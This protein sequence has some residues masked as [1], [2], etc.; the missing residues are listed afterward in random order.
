MSMNN[1]LYPSTYFKADNNVPAWY[2]FLLKSELLAEHLSNPDPEPSGCSLIKQFFDQ[3]NKPVNDQGQ[4][5]PPPDNKKNRSL[6]FLALQSAALLQWDL[7]IFEKR[8]PIVARHQLFME[9]MKACK[10]GIPLAQQTDLGNAIEKLH[11]HALMSLVLYCRWSARTVVKST[12][13]SKP[14]GRV[15]PTVPQSVPYQANAQQRC[16]ELRDQI[17]GMLKDQIYDIVQFLEAILHHVKRVVYLPNHTVFETQQL[18]EGNAAGILVTC[19]EMHAQICYDLGCLHF[20]HTF[21]E[22]AREMFGHVGEWLK[23]LPEKSSQFCNIDETTLAGYQTACAMMNKQVPNSNL[24]DS[25]DNESLFLKIRSCLTKKGSVLRELRELIL[26]DVY[27]KELST[28]FLDEVELELIRNQGNF[29]GSDTIFDVKWCNAI[30][31]AIRGLDQPTGL[32]TYDMN[33]AQLQ[34]IVGFVQQVAGYVNQTESKCL[35]RFLYSMANNFSDRTLRE[36][37]LNFEITRRLIGVDHR[38]ELLVRLQTENQRPLVLENES[39]ASPEMM[40][41]STPSKTQISELEQ[42]L[43]CTFE[44]YLIK[45]TLNQLHK[46]ADG[47]NFFNLCH[48][49]ELPVVYATAISSATSEA[50]RYDF[51]YIMIAKSFHCFLD[52]DFSAAKQLLSF[53]NSTLLSNE[54]PKMKKIIGNELLK[55]ELTELLADESLNYGDPEECGE[56]RTQLSDVVSRCRQILSSSDQ[57]NLPAGLPNLCTAMLLNLEDLT[58]FMGVIRTTSTAPSLKLSCMLALVRTGLVDRSMDTR[59]PASE[60]WSAAMVIFSTASTASGSAS[61]RNSSKKQ[62]V[63]PLRNL[64]PAN[65]IISRPALIEFAKL[66]KNPCI[67]NIIV[68]LLVHLHR[69]CRTDI[70]S[71]ITSPGT[72][73]INAM[74]PTN[75]DGA[76]LSGPCVTLA[77]REVVAYCITLAPRNKSW[78]RTQADIHYAFNNY[79]AALRVYL[80]LGTYDTNYFNDISSDGPYDDEQVVQRMIKCCMQMKCFTQA[81]VLCQLLKDVDYSTAFKALQENRDRTDAAEVHYLEH[82]WDVQLLEHAAFEHR[83]SGESLKKVVA[84]SAS[85]RPELN[86]NNEPRVGA[87]AKACRK[88]RFFQTMA[89]HYLC[90]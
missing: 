52:G 21:Y 86:Q 65:A 6:K 13:P 12:F 34:R 35:G 42:T 46:V 32:W 62:Q 71:D 10:T 82:I 70:V 61:A 47:K 27:R 64:L 55:I 19:E 72:G 20:A 39:P 57:S 69:L 89:R 30:R 54:E 23:R 90:L 73:S 58:F 37:L 24:E 8:L 4:I 38:N 29:C 75:L 41:E 79:C 85:T 68:S 43:L 40:S 56:L 76:P 49:W 84:V 5:L 25:G 77:L 51:I 9:F 15:T 83:E 87:R 59:K 45:D 26:E 78:I 7:D 17:V 11:D 48:Q 53:L 36:Q 66:I 50:M 80:I 63:E 14:G 44:P 31:R 88:T 60:L 2:E 22:K 67:L 16:D 33:I 81:A 1:L 74:W 18:C 3:A 28:A